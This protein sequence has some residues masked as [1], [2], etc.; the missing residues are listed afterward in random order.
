M[1]LS[2]QRAYLARKKRCDAVIH[3]RAKDAANAPPTYEVQQPVRIKKTKQKTKVLSC[4]EYGY[5]LEGFEGKYFSW[6]AIEPL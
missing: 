4:T 6:H 3:G 2:V 1:V 5:V